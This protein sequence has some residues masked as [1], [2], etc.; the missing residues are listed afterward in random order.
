LKLRFGDLR[1][2]GESRAGTET[3]FRVFPPGLALDAGRGALPLAGAR[4]LFIS[5]GHLDHAL[6][7]P[8][9]LSQR[10]LHQAQDT[11]VLCPAEIAADL[12]DLIEAA[13]RLER[14]SYRYRV[15]GLAPGDRVAVGKNLQVE[16]FRTDHVVPT[17]G[18]TLLRRRH[19]L[20]PEHVGR[21]SQEL[22]E[23]RRRGETITEAVED[24]ALSYCGD[25]GPGVF[26]LAPE[27]FEARV[28]LLE[29]TFLSG[30]LRRRG[31]RY[32]HLHLDDL[33]EH[34]ARFANQALVLH[35]LSRRHR[36]EDLRRA[37][38]QRLPALA[39]RVWLLGDDRVFEPESGAGS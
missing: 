11:R 12:I 10:T 3:W 2:E 15:E 26:E 38:D 8:Y 23:L 30:E 14:A 32:K 37:V 31:E 28:L 16:A 18:F 39:G 5:H 22:V 17:L 24:R 27:I 7:V 1:I 19:H 6:G 13:A 34:A 36:M 20:L 33:V 4:D 35:H 29:C 21:S 9:V 25:T